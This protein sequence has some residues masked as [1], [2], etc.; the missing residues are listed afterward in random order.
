MKVL[1]IFRKI[2]SVVVGD[3]IFNNF[4]QVAP[5]YKYLQKHS[6]PSVIIV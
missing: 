6:E 4:K 3:Y 2:E 1:I 5:T